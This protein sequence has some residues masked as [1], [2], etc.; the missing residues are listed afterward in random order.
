MTI[1]KSGDIEAFKTI[2][3][4]RSSIA[5]QFSLNEEDLELSMGMSAD[6]EEA[7]TYG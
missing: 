2:F 1:G 5:T 7:V 4:L 6:F 3:T